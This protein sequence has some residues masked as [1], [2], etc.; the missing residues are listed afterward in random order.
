MLVE[1]VFKFY[2]E[3]AMMAILNGVNEETGK[4]N[5]IEVK[6]I[7]PGI[8]VIPHFN[9]DHLLKD[10]SIRDRYPEIGEIGPYGVCDHYK[11]V[12][13]RCPDIIRSDRKFC[14]SFTPVKKSEQPNDGGWRW[15]KWGEYIGD[16]QPQHEYLY[17]EPEIEE[18][19]VYHI[20]EL[21]EH[22]AEHVEEGDLRFLAVAGVTMDEV[23]DQFQHVD[24]STITSSHLVEKAQ[25]RVH[26]S[27]LWVLI[28][29]DGENH[30]K[31]V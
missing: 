2:Q 19:L 4:V 11:Q 14:I 5:P 15:H 17:H 27:D 9:F 7:E 29:R 6:R 18:V 23:Q 13:D 1:P 16:H 31:Y 20:Y 12:L 10:N 28:D 25:K 24:G 3:V 30:I 22:N 21:N 8:Y 26:M